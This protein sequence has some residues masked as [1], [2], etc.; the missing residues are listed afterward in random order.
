MSV[1]RNQNAMFR[2]RDICGQDKG[3]DGWIYELQ[4][5]NEEPAWTEITEY[6]RTEP[7]PTIGAV[8]RIPALL[9]S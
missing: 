9:G 4:N 8:G 1:P 2:I 3:E 7:P 5:I 6:E